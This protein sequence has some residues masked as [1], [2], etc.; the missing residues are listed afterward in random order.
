MRKRTS[1]Y[2]YYLQVNPLAYEVAA[3]GKAGEEGDIKYEIE[4][5]I[6]GVH[7]AEDD[8]FMDFKHFDF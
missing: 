6:Q 2:E 7:H 8:F 3:Q 1:D 4:T 5:E